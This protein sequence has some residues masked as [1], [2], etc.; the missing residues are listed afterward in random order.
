VVRTGILNYFL[1]AHKEWCL[2]NVSQQFYPEIPK[3]DGFTGDFFTNGPNKL[4]CDF[5]YLKTFVCHVKTPNRGSFLTSRK[6]KMSCSRLGHPRAK[7]PCAPGA[8]DALKAKC[9]S[10]NIDNNSVSADTS[11]LFPS[12]RSNF[13]YIMNHCRP[14]QGPP[15]SSG[16][17]RR[18]CPIIKGNKFRGVFRN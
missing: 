6:D 4:N 12:V 11:Q 9:F 15:C 7:A 13:E 17:S 18:P 5:I 2:K 16:K 14:F 3:I 1:I 8:F 10:L